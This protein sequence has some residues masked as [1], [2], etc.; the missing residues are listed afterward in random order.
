MNRNILKSER[1]QG[2]WA[3]RPHR[4]IPVRW[5]PTLLELLSSGFFAATR[6][7][8]GTTAN[9]SKSNNQHPTSRIPN[10][11]PRRPVWNIAG[12]VLR[13]GKCVG[14][15]LVVVGG[16]GSL[17]EQTNTQRIWT[18][19]SNGALTNVVNW[20]PSGAPSVS[21][22]AIFNSTTNNASLTATNATFGSISVNGTS[23]FSFLN[24]TSGATNSNLTLG[25]A[26]NNGNSFSGTASDVLYVT[27]GSS[28][29]IQGP[30]ASSGSGVLNVILGQNGTFNIA[31]TAAI[32]RR[33]FYSVKV[34]G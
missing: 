27:S 34:S 1:P 8:S 15:L 30:N 9:F 28:F 16:V 23:A 4:S 3:S 25:G 7:G 26:G 22:D 14:L 21:V 10:L 6:R 12:P 31:G 19:G 2:E 13:L 24:R 32:W 17:K 20:N 33:N 29:T 18:G 5:T 11:L